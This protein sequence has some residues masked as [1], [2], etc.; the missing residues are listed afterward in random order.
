[1]IGCRHF[2]SELHQ[3]GIVT[4]VRVRDQHGFHWSA[5]TSR[6]SCQCV[7]H[8]QLRLDR[9]RRFNQ[10]QRPAHAV[11][12]TKSARVFPPARFSR[13]GAARLHTPDMRQAA[14]L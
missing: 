10:R 9:R 14:V 11:M 5:N 1:M 8:G 7:Q 6:D 2:F 3:A 12:H 13:L 4:D